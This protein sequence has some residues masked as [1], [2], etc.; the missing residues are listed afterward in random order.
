LVSQEVI[1]LMVD[2]ESNTVAELEEFIDR[3]IKFQVE[4][5][6]TQEQYD[7]ILM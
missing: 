7:L 4:T 5:M 2:E 6:Y 1:D 3:P